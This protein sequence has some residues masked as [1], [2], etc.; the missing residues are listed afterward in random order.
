MPRISESG[1]TLGMR[2]LEF[3]DGSIAYDVI[4]SGQPLVMLRGL[5]RSVS[6]WL[7]YQNELAKEHQVIT[8]DLRGVG[9]TTRPWGLGTS[10]YDLADDVVAVLD[11]LG[12]DKAHVLGVSLG[13]MVTLATGIR[14]P[15]RCRSLI[16][17]NTSIAGMRTMRLTPQAFK[18]LVSTARLAPEPLQAA[19]VDSL[20]GRACPDA[21]KSYIAKEYLRIAEAEGL[22]GPTAARQLLSAGRFYPI[23]RLKTM[24]VPTMVVYGT[25]DR[26]VPTINSRKLVQYIPGAKLVPIKDGGHELTLDKPDELTRVVCGWTQGLTSR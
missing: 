11:K 2:H 7:G 5:A 6:H 16:T 13:G 1:Y 8:L 15:E 14:H 12:I 18:V 10:I 23:R 25:D 3:K 9:R 17:I 19:L 4:G 22:Y 26:F 24:R 21:R 20:V